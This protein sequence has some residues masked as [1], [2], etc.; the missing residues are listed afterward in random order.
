MRKYVIID[1]NNIVLGVEF[2]DITDDTNPYGELWYLGKAHWIPD[3]LE[4]EVGTEF[5]IETINHGTN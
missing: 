2:R 5:N 1:E 4:P 3:D